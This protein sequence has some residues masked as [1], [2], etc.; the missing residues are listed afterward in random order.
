MLR[1]ESSWVRLSQAGAE[2]LPRASA[3]EAGCPRLYFG[4]RQIYSGKEVYFGRRVNLF[5]DGG[6]F[7]A[8]LVYK[9]GELVGPREEVVA[10][11]F[12]RVAL[13][14]LD[15]QPARAAR[16]AQVYQ[17]TGLWEKRGGGE[18]GRK[19]TCE[20]AARLFELAV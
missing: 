2:A 10:R 16:S 7:W 3:A 6:Q 14:H 13:L 17:R 11:A 8:H 18:S 5:W 9:V 15:S 1:L 20:W 19:A 12:D 4:R